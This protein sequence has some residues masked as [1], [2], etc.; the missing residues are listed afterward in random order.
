MV[1]TSAVKYSESQGSVGNQL[2]QS[3]IAGKIR[4]REDTREDTG[5]EP[6]S[7]LLLSG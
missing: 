1:V 4:G 6:E 3:Q 7:V 5:V 2:L